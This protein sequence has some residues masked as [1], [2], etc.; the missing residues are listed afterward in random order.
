MNEQNSHIDEILLTRFLL[1]EVSDKEMQQVL[2]WLHESPENQAVLDEIEK[3]W[4]EAGKLT[5][6]P[7]A[8]DKSLAWSKLSAKMEA[9]EEQKEKGR[10]ITLNTSWVWSLST[11][12]VILLVVGWF[13][14]L[15][16][17]EQMILQTA[18][19]VIEQKLPDGS[20][21]SVNRGSKVTYPENFG[22]K[23]RTVK[24]QGEAFFEVASNKKKPFIVDAGQASVLVL[25][26]RFNV[27]AL[28]GE[29]VEVTVMEGLVKLFR[30]D[31][32]SLDTAYIMLQAGEVGILQKGETQPEKVEGTSPD[33]LFWMDKTLIF[34]QTELRH[35]FKL[36]EQYYDITIRVDKRTI[37][38]CM[39]TA[40]F[41]NNSIREI[42]DIISITL[43]L[44]V[45]KTDEEYIIK[46]NGC[47][48]E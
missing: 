37:N 39:L 24:L 32:I 3:V 23:Q 41:S 11:A 1:G 25:G 16:T 2:K 12:A 14:W 46:G 29:E 17:P 40:T 4:L 44:E 43:H 45:E 31:S 38:N 15:K 36:L 10:K 19:A 28:P 6:Q 30:V 33:E 27:K 8:V 34:K 7:V 48:H 20:Q 26:T 21:V 22:R 35:V 47:N 9:Y 18:D 42:L 13:L 5:P